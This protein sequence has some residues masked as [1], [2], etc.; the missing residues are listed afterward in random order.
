[1]AHEV[2]QPIDLVSASA[3]DKFDLDVESVIYKNN[4][5]TR[6]QSRDFYIGE[7]AVKA[8]AET[9]L[10]KSGNESTAF[11]TRRLERAV[12]DNYL[13]PVVQS[14][15]SL[16]WSTSP[17][18]S[19]GF[20]PELEL[21]IKDVDRNG[22]HIDS[23]MSQASTDALVD[24]ITWI[25]VD[26]DSFDDSE[27]S[28]QEAAD[29]NLRPFAVQVQAEDVIDYQFDEHGLT[30]LVMK[31][32]HSQRVEPGIDA[33]PIDQR[34]VWT[35]DQFAIFQPKNPE[36]DPSKVKRKW[37]LVGTIQ[38]NKIK[39]V[40]FVPVY[41]WWIAEFDG[42]PIGIDIIGHILSIYNKFSDRDVAEMLT[43]NPVPYII[44]ANKPQQVDLADGNGLWVEALSGLRQE[45][46]YLEH[47]GNGLESSRL[48]E[49]ELIN[50]IYEI[51]L[52][53]TKMQTRQVESAEGQRE[54]TKVFASSLTSVS[55]K[56][57]S[58]EHG[59]W[60]LMLMYLSS[61]E[62]DPSADAIVTYNKEYDDNEID[63]SFLTALGKLVVS[64]TLSRRTLLEEMK[65]AGVIT[66]EE[67][68]IE[69]ELRRI[70]SDRDLDAMPGFDPGNEDSEEDDG[71]NEAAP[72]GGTP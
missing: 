10:L 32:L 56:L 11:Y 67:W 50:R 66:D 36:V 17:D 24:G 34:L 12:F 52:F 40:P 7:K 31:R 21:F 64:R 61:K 42:L 70:E 29:R 54:N 68:D 9:Y 49:R 63:A 55:T 4:K 14:R 72:Q 59:V 16:M 43:N 27:I 18:R 22:T 60:N 35:R 48:S 38:E 3:K 5:S 13:K 30:F 51:A 15:T 58:S 69:E 23:L 57:Q 65:R 33:K 25:K 2:A 53:Q 37:V 41:G 46:A 1:M 19:K 28:K 26:S 44:S 47:S 8:K 20:P 39:R 6:R 62:I 71:E 45:V